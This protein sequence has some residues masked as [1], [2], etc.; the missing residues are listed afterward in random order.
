ML[1]G[2]DQLLKG[3]DICPL[4]SALISAV[5]SAVLVNTESNPAVSA[6]GVV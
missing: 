5:S 1:D 3:L 2:L 4:L 6:L